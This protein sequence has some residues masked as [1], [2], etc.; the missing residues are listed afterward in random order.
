MRAY[1]HCSALTQAKKRQTNYIQ[2]AGDQSDLLVVV[3]ILDVVTLLKV[4][5]GSSVQ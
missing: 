2:T 3:V 5:V 1:I 4:K